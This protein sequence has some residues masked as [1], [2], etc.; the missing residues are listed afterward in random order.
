MV[1]AG[2]L[3]VGGGDELK[4]N[5][6]AAQQAELAV[7]D[8]VN[9]LLTDSGDRPDATSTRQTLPHCDAGMRMIG[10][11]RTLEEALL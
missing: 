1:R 6:S 9:R 5:L 8:G 4:G 7:A 11:V 10:I 2:L 3:A